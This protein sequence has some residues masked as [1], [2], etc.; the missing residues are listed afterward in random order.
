MELPAGKKYC[1]EEV[2]SDAPVKVSLE[3]NTLRYVPE[4]EMRAVAIR[5]RR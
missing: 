1:I 5:F 2:F 3:G 4:E